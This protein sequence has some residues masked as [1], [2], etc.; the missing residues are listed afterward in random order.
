VLPF[1]L[2]LLDGV[3]PGKRRIILAQVVL[4]S[5]AGQHR[6]QGFIAVKVVRDYLY[7]FTV[8]GIDFLP[9]PCYN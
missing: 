5:N 3:L 1:P 9:M 4:R 8:T 2:A 6:P 7:V